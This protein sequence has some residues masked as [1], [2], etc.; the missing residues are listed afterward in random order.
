MQLRLAEL[1][2]LKDEV[3]KAF[4]FTC[5][6]HVSDVTMPTKFVPA[7]DDDL[8]KHFNEL[9]PVADENDILGL[10][11]R[12]ISRMNALTEGIPL[13]SEGLSHIEN[14]KKEMLAQ[15]GMLARI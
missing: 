3:V 15:M 11:C 5:F 1:K 13:L 8:R 12:I 7:D 14:Q 6:R 9:F 4:P 10:Y 2:D